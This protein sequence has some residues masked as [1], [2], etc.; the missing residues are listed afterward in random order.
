MRTNELGSILPC[1]HK[2][3]HYVRLE[4]FFI[5]VNVT[6]LDQCCDMSINKT[7]DM[8]HQVIPFAIYSRKLVIHSIQCKRPIST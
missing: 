1:Y 5:A 2:T 8:F 3:S 6:K 7:F 4:A